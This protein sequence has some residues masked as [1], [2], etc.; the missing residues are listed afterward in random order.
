MNGLI[1]ALLLLL[2]AALALPSG[3]ETPQVDAV[4]GFALIDLWHQYSGPISVLL[5]ALV[6]VFAGTGGW[7]VVQN[8]RVR[9]S[10][11]QYRHRS[12][13]VSEVIWGTDAGTWEWNV[14]TGETFLN[15]R[16]AAIIGYTLDELAPINIST[17]LKRTHP[18]DLMRSRE[19]VARCFKREVEN[20]KCEMRVR[21][22]N[23]DW[24]WI[25][26]R[27]RVVEWTADGQP[28][29]MAGT[30][31]DVTERKAAE[32]ALNRANEEL[33]SRETLL[34]QVLDTSSVA[35][36]LANSAGR[37]VHANQ[38]MAEMFAWPLE[39]LLGK[40]YLELIHPAERE[41]GRQKMLALLGCQI[42]SVDLERRYWRAD[43]TEFWGHLT[44]KCFYETR[45]KENNLVGVIADFT[46]RKQ[47]ELREQHRNRVLQML[48]SNASMAS[49]LDVIARDV[50]AIEPAMLCNILL[51]DEGQTLHIGAAP[52]LPDFYTQAINGLAVSQGIDFWSTGAFFAGE[53]II[54]EDIATHPAW[55]SIAS[56]AQRASLGS[57]WSQPIFS[58]NG[59][60]LGTFT[61]Y[62]R[63]ACNPSPGD[64]QMMEEEARLVALTIEKNATEARLQL[65]ASVFI[66]AG[67]GILIADA[68]GIIID[69]NDTFTQ[70]TGYSREEALGQNPR[71][72]QSGRQAPE[73]YV[74]MWQHLTGKGHWTGEM[75]NR[76]K[77]GD[78]YAQMI[79]ITA[80]RDGAGVTQHYV[81]LFSDITP[82]KDYQHQ[83]EHLAHYDALTG[84]P[85][86]VLLADRLQQALAQSQ[87][88]K[89]SLAVAFLDLDGFKT[90][91]DI[92]GHD[93]GDE[94]LTIIAKR[95]EDA[96]RQGD[97]L[98]RLGGDEFVVVLVDLEQ[99]QDYVPVLERMLQTAITPIMV[100][101]ALLQVSASIGATIYPQD[102]ADAE[103]LIRHA[104]Q[105]MYLAKQ[106]GKN[107]YRLFDVAQDTA[108][109][110]QR[111]NLEH[112]RSALDRQEFVLHYQPKVNMK[113]GKV[114]G[115]EALIRW[116][117]PERGLL[118][119][120]AF[121]PVL[122]NQPIGVEVGEWVITTALT[123][124][125]QWRTAG[126]DIPVSVNIGAHQLQQDNF[127]MRLSGILAGYPDAPPGWLELEILETNALEDI[128]NISEI[129]STCR[130]MGVRFALDDFGTGYSSLTYLKRLSAELLK[131]DQSFVRD[132][133]SNHDDRT[134]V[135]GV[136]GLAKAFHREVIAEGVETVAHGELLL[137]LG[138][139][140][141]QGYGIARPM[142]A[143]DLPGWAATWRPSASWTNWQASP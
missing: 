113:T 91:N 25:L 89:S 56:L 134:I 29:R 43:G 53:R 32:H 102:D 15:E 67:E 111:E 119:P 42:P 30:Q 80:V 60:V 112:I 138:C 26:N 11:A 105:A 135:K 141:A 66:H 128:A 116:Q 13:R 100:G 108:V 52:S 55:A 79:T 64:L 34:K 46:E 65:A 69:V 84:L 81:S 140:L 130:A 122:E 28:K 123:Q 10:L 126:L 38:R 131:I 17:W 95:M 22:K 47:G 87:R 133:L 129:I 33:T 88:R 117:H 4:S 109:K 37:I 99:A 125:T 127:T 101:N 35:I 77:N 96:L 85:N 86:R 70:I 54:V 58:T 92:H 103:Q 110:I 90:V 9:R 82:L 137:S 50:E 76:R 136:I 94:L 24:V 21:H 19:M 40:E 104:D 142:P 6:L 39:E 3:A 143:S 1:T 36:F 75:W 78:V 23:G 2:L 98:A 115:A 44:G 132:M 20:Y 107:R 49:V 51:V 124:M 31:A 57:C 45:N 62:H 71:M 72:L 118:P 114:I 7:L 83:L 93:V 74:T 139:E 27:G 73:F 63:H 18:D 120:A 14:Q 59:K 5:G 41:V 16:W 8:R 68:K 12:Q 106:A 48:T 121:L 61:I 97:T